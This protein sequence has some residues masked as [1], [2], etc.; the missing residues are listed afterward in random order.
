MERLASDAPPPTAVEASFSVTLDG[1]R[2][3]AR[4]DRVDAGPDGVIIT[5]YKSGDVPDVRR[6]RQRARDSL[7]LALYALAHQAETRASCRR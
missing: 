7:Q 5:D 1:D 6:A 4:Y 3:V 2:C